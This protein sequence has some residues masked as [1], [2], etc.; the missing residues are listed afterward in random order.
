[1]ENIKKWE[2]EYFDYEDTV[3]D[4]YMVDFFKSEEEEKE[5]N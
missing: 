4:L 5:R 2:M 3:I 1:M